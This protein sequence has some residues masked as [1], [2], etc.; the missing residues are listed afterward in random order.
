M[1]KSLMAMAGGLAL[2][3]APAAAAQDWYANAGATWYSADDAD[4]TGATARLGYKFNDNFGAEGEASF[5]IEG[6]TADFLG[7]PVDVDLDNQFGV[8]AVGWL[9]VSENFDL[10]GRIGYAS[11]DAQGSFGGFSA[12]A[13]DDGAA[14]GVGAQYMFNDTWGVR[15]EYT[16][17]ASDDDGVDA[18][19]VSAVARF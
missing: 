5:G 10:F 11:I 18:V 3:L 19:G 12:G 14:V 16:R 6:D 13:D 2:M 15:G 8:Y 1:R 9:P 17:L 4:V 7:T